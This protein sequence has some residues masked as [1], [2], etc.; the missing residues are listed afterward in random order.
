[1]Q[2]DSFFWLLTFLG[3]SNYVSDI[4]GGWKQSIELRIL[5]NRYEFIPGKLGL[6]SVFY[7]DILVLS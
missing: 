6:V 5:K 7:F 3:I 4:Y 2:K 1:M